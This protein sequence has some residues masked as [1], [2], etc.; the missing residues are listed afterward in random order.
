MQ[1]VYDAFFQL[2]DRVYFVERRKMALCRVVKI[3]RDKADP[4]YIEYV[5]DIVE[6]W[7]D[8]EFFKPL[9]IVFVGK[10]FKVSRVEGEAYNGMWQ[11]YTAQ[12]FE[13]YY[14][15]VTSNPR[16]IRRVRFKMVLR[17]VV[18]IGFVTALGLWL[19]IFIVTAI[20]GIM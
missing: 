15:H 3:N 1:R 11:L 16:N 7:Y 20:N 8:H 4:K 13:K 10:R 19:L 12:E 18:V 17:W 6:Q 5:L 14:G 2:G 9:P